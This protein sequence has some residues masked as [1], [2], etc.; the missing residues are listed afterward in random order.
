MS[1]LNKASLIQIPSGYK[2]GTLY[3]AKPTN[4]DGDFTFSR[5]SNLAATRVNSEGLIE[6]GRENLLKYSGDLTQSQWENIRT[7]DTTGHTGY[8]GTTDA[9]KIIP[10]IDNNT[11]RLDYNDTWTTGQLY[12]FSLYAKADGYNTIDVV[13]GDTSVSSNYGRFNLSTGTA[14][15]VG[16]SIAT[17]MED[18]GGGWYRCQTAQL[19]GSTTR[20]NIGIND[21]TTQSYAGDGTSG[22]LIQHPQLEQGLVATDYIET[23]TTTEQAGILEDMPR[24][25][26][27]G[28]ATCGH[29]LLEPQRT[30]LVFPSEDITAWSTGGMT[31]TANQTTSPDG[32]QNAGK[33]TI[34]TA[35]RYFDSTL[36]NLTT[37]NGTAYTTSF[38]AKKGTGIEAVYFYQG[39][40]GLIAKWNLNNGTYIGHAPANGYSAFTS[41]TSESFGNGWYRFTATYTATSTSGNY[42]I[43]VST[44]TNDSVTPLTGN[45]TDFVYVW[46]LQYE[47]GSY[48]TSLIPTYGS[49]VTRS[50]DSCSK[51]GISSL[52]GGTSGTVFFDITTNPVLTS[53]SYKQFFYYTDSSAN[54]GYMYLNSGNV[55]VTNPPFG[56]LSSSITLTANTRYKIALT[57]AN[58]DFAIYVNG[59]SVATA[60]SGTSWD[61]ENLLSLGSYTGVSEFN[62]FKF[63]Q[64]THFKTRLTND[65]LA[66]LTTI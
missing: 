18:L 10:T 53:A 64:Y 59:T 6:K 41:Q 42:T 29:L 58:N 44:N 66:S 22:V 7:T 31:N 52:I 63:N 38:F 46:G 45:G 28:G 32:T 49:S 43:G 56:N 55:I 36:K 62:E 5:G 20:I 17:S 54:Q 8:D 48:S 2:D 12:T 33:S 40:G 30:N 24:L 27:S 35:T 61:F 60:S 50:A 1:L 14:S 21:G 4:G 34:G 51:T 25:D 13:I 26:Y 47:A 15:N 9:F 37:V 57:Y 16:A 11:H 39:D 3:S 65:E 19:S 23:T